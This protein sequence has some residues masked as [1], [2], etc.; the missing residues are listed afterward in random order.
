MVAGGG[1]DWST[2]VSRL[3]KIHAACRLATDL[4]PKYSGLPALQRCLHTFQAALQGVCSNFLRWHALS[5]G[6]HNISQL[7]QPAWQMQQQSALATAQ[8]TWT[9]LYRY[10]TLGNACM[11]L[12][13]IRHMRAAIPCNTSNAETVNIS[14]NVLGHTATL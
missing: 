14:V 3:G 9:Q 12:H 8:A 6:G 11:I 7:I 10:Q 2:S 13:C 1:G 4:F 5:Y